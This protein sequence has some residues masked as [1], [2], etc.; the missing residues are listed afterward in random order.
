MKIVGI[1]HLSIGMV[2]N[3]ANPTRKMIAFFP[4]NELIRKIDLNWPEPDVAE[5]DNSDLPVIT[6]QDWELYVEDTEHKWS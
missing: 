2:S 3:G 1:K 4:A 6:A 5:H